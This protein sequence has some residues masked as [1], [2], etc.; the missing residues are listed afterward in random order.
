MG[1]VSSMEDMQ[2]DT[3]EDNLEEILGLSC[4]VSAGEVLQGALHGVLEKRPPVVSSRV[5]FGLFSRVSSKED[6]LSNSFIYRKLY[7]LFLILSFIHPPIILTFTNKEIPMLYYD[8][9]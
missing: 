2:E 7:L 9:N 3:L 1:R 5:S 4:R 6:T 8:K